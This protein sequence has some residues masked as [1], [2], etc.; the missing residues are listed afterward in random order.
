MPDDPTVAERAVVVQLLDRE[1][2]AMPAELYAAIRDG[3]TPTDI[4]QAVLK[5]T[6]T[7]IIARDADGALRTTAALAHL[8]A[9][10]MICV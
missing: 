3:V 7:G 10:G 4:D 2:A 8:D 1:R 6:E 9:L 5:L